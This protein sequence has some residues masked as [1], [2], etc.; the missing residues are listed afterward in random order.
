M[1]VLPIIGS[2]FEFARLEPNKTGQK[3]HLILRK[4]AAKYGPIVR[5]RTPGSDKDTIFITDADAVADA[6][7]NEGPMPERRALPSWA[8][9]R[10]QNKLPL[11]VPLENGEEWKRLRSAIQTPIFPPKNAFAYC[12][13]L[14]PPTV[15]VMGLIENELRC[16]GPQALAGEELVAMDNL[17]MRWSIED[18]LT[19]ST[20]CAPFKLGAL[21][22]EP[23]PFTMDMIKAVNTVFASTGPILNMPE[24]VWRNQLTSST[25]EHFK[26]LQRLMDLTNK[27]MS[28]TL[29]ES[30]KDPAKLQGTFLGHVLQRDATLTRDEMLTTAVDLLFAGIDTT[31]RTLL[32][33]MNLLSRHP[34]A[35]TKLRNEIIAVVGADPDVHLDASHL[36][37]LKYMKNVIKES[38]RL[39]A[40]ISSNSRFLPRDTVVGGYMIPAGTEVLFGIEVM[41]HDPKYFAD[42]ESFNPD[43]WGAKDIH[44]F[45][46]LPFGFGPR[47]CVGRRIAE[48]EMTV[49]LAHLLRKFEIMPSP[50]PTDLVFNLVIANEKPMPLKFR[51][52]GNSTAEAAV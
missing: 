47:M 21:D 7:R 23:N 28:T 12:P 35:Q 52:L 27:I 49:F 18:T 46:S 42:P 41:S 31:S 15:Q 22:D 19:F 29:S 32:N 11:G 50:P 40:I 37:K 2:G 36:A 3:F 39:Y 26:A 44:P 51:P 16:A 34:E 25:R 43:R 13:T 5:L 8:Y 20:L 6:L 4:I 17:V 14:G 30:T 48:M 24:F 45:A 33:I 1:P 38:M 10:A 9:F